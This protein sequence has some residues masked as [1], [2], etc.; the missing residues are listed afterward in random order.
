M[1]QV[2][3]PCSQQQ[4]L[5]VDPIQTVLQLQ[6]RCTCTVEAILIGAA[7]SKLDKLEGNA[8]RTSTGPYFIEDC[9]CWVYHDGQGS[10]GREPSEVLPEANCL[11]LP[12]SQHALLVKFLS[13][14]SLMLF[15]SD[16]L[17]ANTDN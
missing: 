1:A 14:L 10:I 12:P 15:A 17:P 3:R 11:S 13:P 2:Y 8:N 16:G 6:L 9:E 5:Q 4:M 7:W